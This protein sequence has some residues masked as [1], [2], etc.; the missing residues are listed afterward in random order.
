VP[1]VR[2]EVLD[3]NPKIA[4]VADKVSGL[5]DEATISALNYKVDGEKME[6]KDVSADFLKAKG[7]LK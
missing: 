7:V 5:L 4:E 6:P 2:K 3:A 1:V